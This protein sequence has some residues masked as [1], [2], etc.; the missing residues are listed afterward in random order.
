MPAKKKTLASTKDC[1]FCN[2]TPRDAGLAA[3]VVRM[4]VNDLREKGHDEELVDAVALWIVPF[5]GI[6]LG[7]KP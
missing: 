2:M 1:P 7:L 5:M 4:I 3:A 6:E